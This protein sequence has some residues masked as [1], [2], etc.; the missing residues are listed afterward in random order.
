MKN[1]FWLIF[2]VSFVFGCQKAAE[3][4]VPEVE[5][6][7]SP[8]IKNIEKTPATAAANNLSKIE[9]TKLANKTAAE[10]DKIFGAPSEVKDIENGGKYHLY[11]SAEYPK[12]LAIRFY[13][14]K[15]KS[16]N[17][18]LEKPFAGSKEVITKSFGIDVGGA[19]AIQDKTEPLSENYQG[20]FGGV[21]F[22]KLAAKR[23]EKGKDFIFVLAEIAP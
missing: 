2:A 9:V 20:T 14:D 5:T 7:Q 21:K 15:A 23:Q 10:I 18:I 11:K 1:Y 8:G 13:G 19:K 22:S 6:A 3:I 12:G 4:K 17:L 16:F